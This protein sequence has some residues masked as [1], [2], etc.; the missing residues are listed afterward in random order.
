MPVKF[1]L[2]ALTVGVIGVALYSS[3]VSARHRAA[4][5]YCDPQM[6]DAVRPDIQALNI[7][8][9]RQT[10]AVTNNIDRTVSLAA[11]LR[12]GDDRNRWDDHK[13]GQLV[14]YVADVKMGGIETVNCHARSAHGRDTHIDLTLSAA[15]AYNE[16]R[17]VIVEVTPRWRTAMAAKGIDWETDTLREKLLG[18][19]VKVTGWLL[20]D[21]EHR[22]Q[23]ANTADAGAKVWRAT[24]WEIHPV[25]AMEVL[26]T[27][28]RQH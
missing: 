3:P 21:A 5:H 9:N 27:C 2:L 26:P 22:R 12:P 13:A 1:E 28:G 18:R 20:F 7:L 6:G 8:K 11:M 23:S 16:A 15:D 10:A 19:C 17:H 14:G 25:T 4:Y 24:A